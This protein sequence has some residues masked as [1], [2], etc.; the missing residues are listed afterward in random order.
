MTC[1]RVS[2]FNNLVNSNGQQFKCLQWS[3]VVRNTIDEAEALSKAKREFESAERVVNW[4]SRAHFVEIEQLRS[5]PGGN[6]VDA[7]RA[8]KV[9]RRDQ[10]EER[11]AAVR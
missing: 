9:E 3:I 4:A 1:Y 2:F 11:V 6:P 7:V 5:I 10:A 8:V